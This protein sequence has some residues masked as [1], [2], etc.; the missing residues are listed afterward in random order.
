MVRLLRPLI[1]FWAILS[2]YYVAYIIRSQTNFFTTIDIAT[3]RVAVEELKIYAL[4]SA[5]IFVIT[6]IIHQRYNLISISTN[7]KF[8]T[9]WWQR[10]IIVT[11]FAYFWQWFFFANGISRLVIIMTS[12]LV[13]VIVPLT[14]WIRKYWYAAQLKRHPG[15]I[16]FLL[17]DKNQEIIAHQFKT[18]KHYQTTI[19]LFTDIDTNSLNYDIIVLVGSY[20]K[21]QLQDIIDIMRLKNTQLYHIGDNHFLEDVIYT[22]TNFW[23]LMSI[24]Y[25]AS[26]IEGRS[27]IFKRI[28]DISGAIVGIIVATPLMLVTA[29]A[30]KLDTKWPIFY[31]QQRVWKNGKI[32]R[33]TKFRSMYTHLSTWQNYGGEKADK[34]YA[35]LVAS[36]ANIR[37]GELPKIKND[38]RVTPVWRRLRATSIDEIPNLFSVLHWD[39]SLVWP[40]PHL[41]SE[42]ANYKPW[43]RRV[44]S[45]KPGITWYAQIHGRDSLS[46][47]EEAT[48][49]LEYIQNRSLWLDIVIIFRTFGVIF[50]GKGK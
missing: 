40:R 41:P 32:F 1:H 9:V 50:G 29:L 35:D 30:I 4:W 27:A 21:D 36:H 38:P 31:R 42:I 45:I 49:E 44:L 8:L 47:D 39:M 13:F 18:P 19:S 22:H 5:I 33:F 46:F 24:R 23:N 15:Q 11:C 10:L 37:P 6:G 26:Q 28:F 14:D 25:T 12:L 7:R 16:L 17:Q 20:T 48:K 3:P 43:Q 2:S 34:L